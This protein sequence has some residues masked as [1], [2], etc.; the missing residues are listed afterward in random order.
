MNPIVR[1]FFIIFFSVF[2][3]ELGDKTQLAT[4]FFA[5]NKENPKLFVFCA[6]ALALVLS[7]A[8][9]V[10]IGDVVARYLSPKVVSWVAGISFIIIG[11]WT[12]LKP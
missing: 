10:L 3:A 6:S 4:L 8:I 11:I 12:I 5:T 1:N 9:A 2:L 7:A